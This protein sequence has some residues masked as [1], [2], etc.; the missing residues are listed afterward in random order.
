[1]KHIGIIACSAEGA[2][3]CYT[4][5]VNEAGKLLGKNIHP[6]ISMHTPPLSQYIHF[7]EEDDWSQVGNLMLD[8]IKKLVKIGVEFA[9]IPDN[10]IHRAFEYFESQSPIPLLH[11]GNEVLKQAELSNYKSL[12]VLGTKYLMEGPVYS[13]LMH[14]KEINYIIPSKADRDVIN[15]IIFDELTSGICTEKSKV[16]SSIVINKLKDSG[17]DAVILGCTELPLL[18]S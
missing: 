14:E 12:G 17:C 18:I 10:T 5:I 7:I 11:I 16:Y 6:E 9:I 8:S 2:A 3:L 13:K 4:T 1:M 15:A